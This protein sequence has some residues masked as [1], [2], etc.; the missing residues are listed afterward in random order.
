[1]PENKNELLGLF[2]DSNLFF[3]DH[4]NNLCKKPSQKLNALATVAPYN[5][6]QRKRKILKKTLITAHL[7]CYS[8]I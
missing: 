5:E 7:G 6:K 1:M 2:L 4:T 3:Q 8:L